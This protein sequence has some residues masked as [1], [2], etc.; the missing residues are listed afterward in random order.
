MKTME[1]EN[2]EIPDFSKKNNINCLLGKDKTQHD[3]FKF[4]ATKDKYYYEDLV[5]HP[6]GKYAAIPASVYENKIKI[7]N[8]K[9]KKTVKTLSCFST[10]ISGLAFTH[11]SKILAVSQNNSRLAFWD[12]KNKA[13]I[14]TISIESSTAK[15]TILS[16]VEYSFD[17]KKLFSFFPG[18]KLLQL[19]TKS[20]KVEAIKSDGMDLFALMSEKPVVAYIDSSNCAVSD[21][22]YC[23]HVW[24]YHNQK[25]LFEYSLKSKNSYSS[26]SFSQDDKLLAIS[27]SNE[28]LRVW[29]THNW[30]QIKLISTGNK[31]FDSY[32]SLQ[33]SPDN[34]FLVGYKSGHWIEISK[35]RLLV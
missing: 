1:L 15:N 28:V 34:K 32:T 33:F 29:D 18:D 14:E 7:W 19:D 26:I 11:N 12:I 25:I 13:L 6:N 16:Q 23:L 17:D 4:I 27:T 10:G 3:F 5:F 2:S 24:D 8:V 21:N 9:Q 35:K 20:K 30:Q 22:Q 31:W